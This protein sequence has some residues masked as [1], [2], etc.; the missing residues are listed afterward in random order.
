M[1]DII[2]PEE[3]DAIMCYISTNG[4]N[5]VPPGSAA[6]YG[7]EVMGQSGYWNQQRRRAWALNEQIRSLNAQGYTKDQIAENMGVSVGMV[8]NRGLKL[9]IWNG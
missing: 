6:P 4:V 2:T 5:R 3:K 7:E 1:P 8:Q 9:G